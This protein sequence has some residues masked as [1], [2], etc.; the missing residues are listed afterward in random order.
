MHPPLH[1]ND[2]EAEI[3][4]LVAEHAG[5]PPDRVTLDTDLFAD[6]GLTG[7]E[8]VRL[9]QAIQSRYGIDL[10]AFQFH[11]HF[12]GEADRPPY[13]GSVWTF[14][15]W[16]LLGLAVL[17]VVEHAIFWVLGLLIGPSV[18]HWAVVWFT[19][20]AV[21]LAVGWWHLG[22][23]VLPGPRAWRAQRMP[24]R[25]RDL[26]RAAEERRWSLCVEPGPLH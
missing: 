13:E 22:G 18:S 9:L 11:R 17:W 4:A 25:P 16:C 14:W 19:L 10:A 6:L 5:A 21:P 20:T 15:L 12:T 3:I 8:A 7:T 1:G 24:I 23:K 26:V 2:V